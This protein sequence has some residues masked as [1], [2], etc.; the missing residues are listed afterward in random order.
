MNTLSRCLTPFNTVKKS[1]AA[2]RGHSLSGLT[3]TRVPLEVECSMFGF[4]SDFTPI[5]TQ[6]EQIRPIDTNFFGAHA[7]S[8]IRNRKS[9]LGGQKSNP[10]QATLTWSHMQNSLLPVPIPR[11]EV[12][13]CR[14]RTPAV[15]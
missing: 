5:S 13:E 8:E 2:L 1:L 12:H 15:G 3:L 14:L 4:H 7:Q 9:N 11:E 10:V 6:S